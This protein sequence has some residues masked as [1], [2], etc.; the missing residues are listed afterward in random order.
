MDSIVTKINEAQSTN[1]D[2]ENTLC[3]N[4]EVFADA[5][6][7]GLSLYK[8]AN[9]FHPVT[10]AGSR[11]WEEIVGIF[12]QLVVDQH[13][14]WVSAQ[15][16]GIPILINSSRNQTIVVTS[17]DKNT[18]LENSVQPKTR[19]AKGDVT[20]AYVWKNFDL[21]EGSLIE[22]EVVSIDGHQT[23][24][25]LY[26][27]D[28]TSKELRYELSLPTSTSISGNNGKIKISEWKERHIFPSIP[29][30]N[31]APTLPLP[32]VEFSDESSFFNIQKK[33]NKI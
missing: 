22:P 9:K 5:M 15:Q 20:Q 30:E 21:F 16:N 31:I 10:T 24:V 23:W 12:R 11:A 14:K 33:T 28:K 6:Q 1:N 3:I 4:K 8:S 29:F 26:T 25:L 7:G 32:K 2:L 19:N 18:G 13:E 27:I 17:G